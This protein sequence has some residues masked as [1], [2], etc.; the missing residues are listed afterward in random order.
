MY[1]LDIPFSLKIED[2][3]FESCLFG[4]V[5]DYTR[6]TFNLLTVKIRKYRNTVLWDAF[7]SLYFIRILRDLIT[8]LHFRSLHWPR[9]IFGSI[10][11]GSRLVEMQFDFGFVEI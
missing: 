5:W 10:A 11:C 1:S 4:F 7:Y 8:A 3:I 9:E 6:Q 2:D